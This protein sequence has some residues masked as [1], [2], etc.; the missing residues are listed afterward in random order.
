VRQTKNRCLLILIFV[1]L[2]TAS[3]CCVQ[4]YAVL[5]VSSEPET[6]EIWSGKDGQYLGTTPTINV[7]R[8]VKRKNGPNPIAVLILQ[9]DQYQTTFKVIEID[10]WA[11]D[12]QEANVNQNA[13]YVKLTPISH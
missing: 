5:Y 11:A 8:Y 4:Q 12:W 10:K 3:G 6:A 1:V 9:K 7:I 13:L 2:S